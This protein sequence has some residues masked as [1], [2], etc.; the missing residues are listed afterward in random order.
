MNV[1]DTNQTV[2][3]GRGKVPT[4]C[5]VLLYRRVFLLLFFSS[6]QSLVL[7][8]DWTKRPLF[9]HGPLHARVETQVPQ[10]TRS[11]DPQLQIFA[12]KERNEGS[13][14][15]FSGNCYLSST[16]KRRRELHRTGTILSHGYNFPTGESLE[17]GHSEASSLR[18]Y[19]IRRE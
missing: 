2:M 19:I 18:E 17:N 14:P 11:Q 3:D 10:G 16:R 9:N 8:D 13:K 7:P 6:L 12:P 15:C 5:R 1:I 4:S